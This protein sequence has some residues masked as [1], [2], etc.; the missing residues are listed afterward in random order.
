MTAAWPIFSLDQAF[1][2]VRSALLAGI[3]STDEIDK[4]AIAVG[5]D[6]YAFVAFPD[7]RLE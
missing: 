7:Q 1:L 2:M 4:Y 6:I 5:K 3:I